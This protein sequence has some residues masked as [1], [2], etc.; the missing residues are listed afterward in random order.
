MEMILFKA[1]FGILSSVFVLIGSIPYFNDIRA[2]RA[3]PHILSWLGWGFLTALGASAMLA[4]G[5]TWAV[6]ILFANTGLCLIIALYSIIT[7]AGVWSTEGKWDFVFF[8]IGVV[9]LILWQVLDLPILSLIC[10]IF[11]DFCF[12]LPTI[13][14]TFKDPSTETPFVWGMCVVSEIFAMFALQNFSFHESA[15]PIYLFIFDTTVFLL[16]LKLIK[17]KTIH[18]SET[19]PNSPR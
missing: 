16:V 18:I 15:Y 10:A 8:G 4:E 2:K 6:V 7:K 11:A 19:E 17:R 14:K 13:I 12:G 3:N 5:S 9:G 1:I